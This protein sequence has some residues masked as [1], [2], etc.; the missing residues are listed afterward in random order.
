MKSR[1]FWLIIFLAAAVLMFSATTLG[2]SPY[3]YGP[4]PQSGPSW[5]GP[6]WTGPGPGGWQL[7]QQVR[8]LRVERSADRDNYYIT[9][10]VSGM[11]PQGVTVTVEG[12]RWL[13]IR[14]EES[15]E[16]SYENSAQ[17]GSAYYRSFS[18]SSG[19]SDRRISLPQDADTAA[20][21]REDSQGQVRITIP[22]RR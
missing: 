11:Q 9:I 5:S 14:T 18:Y 8:Q 7:P 13:A 4:V 16:S 3:G 1:I 12:D 21:Q 20:M 19:S 15:R 22:R 10:L 2:W 6:G 17:D